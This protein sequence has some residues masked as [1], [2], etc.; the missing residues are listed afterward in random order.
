M[1]DLEGKTKE[2]GLFLKEKSH[3][4]SYGEGVT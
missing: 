2:F 1:K 3:Q 4:M